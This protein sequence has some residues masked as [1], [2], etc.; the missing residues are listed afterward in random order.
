MC[1]CT[2]EYTWSCVHGLTRFVVK[3]IIGFRFIRFIDSYH[4]TNLLNINVF[5]MLSDRFIFDIDVI[6]ESTLL[7]FLLYYIPFSSVCSFLSVR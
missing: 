7:L 2:N 1:I 4:F 6:V 5:F 3:S